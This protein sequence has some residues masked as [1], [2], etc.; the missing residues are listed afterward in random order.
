MRRVKRRLLRE[1]QGASTVIVALCMTAILIVL[2]LVVDIGAS[3]ARKAQ[4]QDAADAAA[5]ALAQQCY[6]DDGTTTLNGCA[7]SVRDAADGTATSIA[8]ATMNDGLA[9]LTAEPDFASAPESV[10]VSLESAQTALFSWAAGSDGAVV[11]ASATAEWRQTVALPFAVNRC[12]LDAAGGTDVAFIG[13]G[14]YDGLQNTVDSALGVVDELGSDGSLVDYLSDVLSCG[15][16]VLAGGWLASGS[17]NADC[18]YDPNPITTLVSILDR[19][20]PVS[21]CT[22]QIRDLV[23]KR[24]IVPVYDNS[25]E[26]LLGSLTSNAIGD[27]TITRYAEIIVTGYEF[28]HLLGIAPLESYPTAAQPSC[29]NSVS[30]ILGI[31]DGG[32]AGLL[33]ELVT[34]LDAFTGGTLLFYITQILNGLL[35]PLTNLVDQAL[36]NL[37]DPLTEDLLDLV[38]LCQGIQGQIVATDYSAE[39]AAER[40]IPYRLVS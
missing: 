27:A 8:R 20:L 36:V 4:L 37:V 13:S 32:V 38:S 24:I 25:T 21:A 12:V 39:Q 3:A 9:D 15:T 7:I 40:L 19:V 26:T 34:K 18:T 2:A 16:D 28:N 14:I 33:D 35:G 30:E 22:E 23:G 11:V 17:A 5:M 29:V 6:E 1:Q 31:T 10:T